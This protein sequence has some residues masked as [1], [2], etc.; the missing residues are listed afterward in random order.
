MKRKSARGSM[1]RKWD[2]HLHAP[3]TK[4][5]DQFNGDEDT[6]WDEYCFRLYQSDVQAFGITD[7]FSADPYFSTRMEY[8]RRYPR[9]SKIFLP[10]IELRTNYVVNKAH[11][12]VNVHL[13]FNPFIANHEQQIKNFLSSL[14]T[15]KTDNNNRHFRAS[16]LRHRA[17]FEEA[18]TT[19][20]F[21][22]EALE[23]I[24]G[25]S[26]A[27]LDHVLIVTAANNDGIRP[28]R[29]K[30]RKLLITDELDKFSHAFF[31]GSN[32]REYFL[33]THR[34][35]DKTVTTPQKPVLSGCDAHSFQ[36]L[37]HRLG[38]M[39]S[40]QSDGIVCEPTWIKGDLTF[41]GL[42]QI[43]FEP[44][45]RVFIGEEPES[46]RRVREHSTRYIRALHVSCI[47]SYRGQHGVWFKD[48]KIPFGKELVAIIGNKG[49]GKSAITD[50]LGLLGN[51]HK[52]LAPNTGRRREELFSFL[53]KEKFL[54][55]GCADN[56][57]GILHWYGGEPDKRILSDSV[58]TNLSE[59]VEYLPQKYLERLCANIAD[60]EFRITLNKVIFRY[61]KPQHRHDKTDLESLIEYL[62]HQADEEIDQWR[63]N[64]RSANSRVVATEKKL[65]ANYRDE[66]EEKLR[67]K[68]QELT[69][70]DSLRPQAVPDP[71]RADM[72]SPANESKDIEALSSEIEKHT[73]TINDLENEQTQTTHI[74][75]R[76]RHLKDAIQRT[77]GNLTNLKVQY[78]ELFE[79]IPLKFEEI[80][81]LSIDYNILDKLIAENNKRI[82]EIESLLAT[83]EEIENR[84][85][86]ELNADDAA[87]K[88]RSLSIV[89]RRSQLEGQRIQLVEKQTKPVR[90]YQAYLSQLQAWT[91]RRNAILGDD[92]NPDPNSV[93]G[94][95]NELKNI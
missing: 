48:T 76:L 55:K 95:Q 90:E 36:D 64:L 67:L 87:E 51:S 40:V 17:Q 14:K 10:N 74:V 31:G 53:N 59:K 2:L 58:A 92:Q 82:H 73:K 38:K 23:D 27:L 18:T 50:I 34:G 44:A 37:D 35:E 69:Q 43:I 28:I 60:D 72:A 29:G 70:H 21:I 89:C 77:A 8:R 54:K 91:L 78:Q 13:I 24:Y 25:K 52:Q 9:S 15:N 1:W 45:N 85:L 22:S 49:S 11:E 68:R 5:N 47:D 46:E 20:E 33:D 39:A 30:K 42:R 63:Q 7:Y 80:V 86:F 71:A 56:F 93:N 26:A 4:L 84:F 3:G 32:N 19:R 65:T 66:I 16:D 81:Q 75:Q 94:F 12:E 61:V 88:A 6:L 83:E 79:I 62:T 41:E 57:A